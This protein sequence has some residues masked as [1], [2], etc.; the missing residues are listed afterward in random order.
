[1]V[2]CLA[3]VGLSDLSPVGR[4]HQGHQNRNVADRLSSQAHDVSKQAD[5][6]P[7]G[8]SGEELHDQNLK[9]AAAFFGSFEIGKRTSYK[10]TRDQD[11]QVLWIGAGVYEL[12]T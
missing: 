2:E 8:V 9:E 6:K 10:C 5:L 1:M 12:I 7:S 3:N 11:K 4:V